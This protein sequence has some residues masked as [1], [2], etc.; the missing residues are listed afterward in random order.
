MRSLQV[1]QEAVD[2]FKAVS[3]LGTFALA[4]AAHMETNGN[5]CCERLR[6]VSP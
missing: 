1:E 6:G 5:L 3:D 2:E 4:V